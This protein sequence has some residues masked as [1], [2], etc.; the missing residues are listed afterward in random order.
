MAQCIINMPSL[1]LYSTLSQGIVLSTTAKDLGEILQSSMWKQVLTCVPLTTLLAMYPSY[2]LIL[3][4]CYVDSSQTSC[5]TIML[6]PCLHRQHSD[7]PPAVSSGQPCWLSMGHK[8]LEL[9]LPECPSMALWCRHLHAAL[10][11]QWQSWQMNWGYQWRQRLDPRVR[12][13]CIWALLLQ[14]R[15]LGSWHLLSWW[16]LA[17][18]F[19]QPH[20]WTWPCHLAYPQQRYEIQGYAPSKLGSTRANAWACMSCTNGV[21]SFWW[22]LLALQPC[23]ILWG[24][25]HGHLCHDHVSCPWK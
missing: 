8:H 24:C 17:A 9:R 4:Y 19:L 23:L 3:Y 15:P 14:L 21:A 5:S 6:P 20:S 16:S 18:C 7:T 12:R 11:L 2:G 25:L 1:L 13:S 10:Y 22:C